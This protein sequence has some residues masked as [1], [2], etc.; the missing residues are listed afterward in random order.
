VV[1]VGT[2]GYSYDDWVGPFYPPGLPKSDFLTHYAERF[3]CVEINMTYYRIPAPRQPAAWVDR[4]PSDFLFAVKA[5]RLMTHERDDPASLDAFP[6]FRE[7][8]EPIREAGRLGCVL[9][10]FPQSFGPSD[11]NRDYLVFLRDQLPDSPVVCE[12][13]SAQWADESTFG[14]LRQLDLG[15]CC[16]DEPAIQGLMPRVSVATSSVGYLRFHGRNAAKWY[17]HEEAFERYDYLYGGPELAEWIPGVRELAANTDTQFVF[18]N[19][20]YNA[21]A[22]ANADL[23]MEILVEAS[24]DVAGT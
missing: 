23:F 10:Q 15:Y 4:T 9:A 3:Q 24:I 2:S 16:V 12:F 8:I 14:L 13:R 21:Q 19:N 22:V 17:E 7:A 6:Q 18:F 20:H 1:Y 5:N 11:A